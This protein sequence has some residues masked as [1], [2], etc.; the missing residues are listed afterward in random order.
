MAKP[1]D[2]VLFIEYAK[3]FRSPSHSN[4][5]VTCLSPSQSAAFWGQ[6]IV[7]FQA[8]AHGSRMLHFIYKFADNKTKQHKHEHRFQCI[9][10]C[11]LLV[12]ILV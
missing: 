6:L 9:Y 2:T 12:N 3:H 8:T 7:I 11:I 1:T 5:D 10:K 4:R